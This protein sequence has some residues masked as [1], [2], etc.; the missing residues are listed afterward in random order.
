MTRRRQKPL[1]KGNGTHAGVMAATR[2][3]FKDRSCKLKSKY[4][5]C[6]NLFKYVG[7]D[8]KCLHS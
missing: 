8:G 4:L 7:V 2:R 3:A 6:R 5:E 1:H